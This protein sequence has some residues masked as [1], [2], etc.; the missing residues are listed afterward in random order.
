MFD[1]AAFSLTRAVNRPVAAM[2]LAACCV[3]A[4]IPAHAAAQVAAAP[5]AATS[6][7]LPAAIEERLGAAHAGVL[8]EELSDDLESLVAS[9]F[10][11]SER[12]AVLA[13]IALDLASVDPNLGERSRGTV[14]REAA[15][16]ARRSLRQGGRNPA[17]IALATIGVLTDD[18]TDLRQGVSALAR[19]AP[20]SGEL[21]YFQAV[22]ALQEEDWDGAN[23]ALERAHQRGMAD[24]DYARLRAQIEDATPLTALYWR[25]ALIGLGGWL[26][27]F[28]VILA[29]GALLSQLTLAAATRLAGQRDGSARGVGWGVGAAYRAL[30]LMTTLYVY[31][32]LPIVAVCVAALAAAVIYAFFAL[33]RV[34]LYLAAIILGG[35]VVTVWALLS[36]FW[37]MVGPRRESDPGPRLDLGAN[38]RLSALLDEV[39]QTIGT[40]KL[41]AVFLTVGTELAVL[42]RGSLWSRLRGKTQRYLILGAGGLEGLSRLEMRSILAHEH[43]HHR[44]ECRAGGSLALAVRNSFGTLARVLAEGGAD[45]RNPAWWFVHW[46]ERLFLRVSQGAAR[47]QE[48]VADRGAIFAYGSAAFVRSTEKTIARETRFGDHLARTVAETFQVN[49]PPRNLYRFQPSVVISDAQMQ[50][51]VSEA[52]T[53]EPL[54][55]DSH[56]SHQQRIESAEAIGAPRARRPDDDESAWSLFED[57]AAI[58]ELLTEEMRRDFRRQRA[59]ADALA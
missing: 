41:D 36:A 34:P 38:P 17:A 5:A 25:S 14:Y 23:T 50:L 54:P 44:T 49:E 10:T 31:A 18:P 16:L 13:R 4:F 22:L 24:A 57:R 20:Q 26:A 32:S 7:P 2:L 47:L 15:Q 30:L 6:A 28:F 42:E 39:A 56:P 43:G 45:W 59:L 3:L 29:L 27:G 52:L 9:N 8:G 12:G 53:C 33:G 40:R 51:I 11:R 21:A 1:A 46:F 19:V 48:I 58:E 55:F 35:A 37:G